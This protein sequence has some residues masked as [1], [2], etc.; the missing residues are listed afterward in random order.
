MVQYR[1]Q[2]AAVAAK[3]SPIAR[4][5]GL[6]DGGTV[7]RVVK[8]VG[9]AV[10]KGLNDSSRRRPMIV[11]VQRPG[12]E[13]LGL[14]VSRTQFLPWGVVRLL[15][16]GV[17]R[18]IATAEA[19]ALVV[20]LQLVGVRVCQGEAIVG[21]TRRC[22]EPNGGLYPV[23]GR[24]SAEQ[25]VVGATLPPHEPGQPARCRQHPAHHLEEPHEVG[26]AGTVRADHHGDVGQVVDPEVGQGAE[27]LDV[28]G[29]DGSHEGAS[30]E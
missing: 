20:E 3:A 12:F 28:D 22:T 29:L 17:V 5:P 13:N 24:V 18:R 27:A 10:A 19:E 16:R 21:R 9:R 23:R 14:G 15:P 25:L 7:R 4:V 6:L 30:W 11:V 2:V 1:S 26:L 8:L